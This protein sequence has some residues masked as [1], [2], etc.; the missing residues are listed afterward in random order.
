MK[1]YV[2]CLTN[3]LN[4]KR[5]VGKAND[6]QVRWES[7]VRRAKCGGQEHLCHAIR[8]WG[9]QAFKLEVLHECSSESEAF[10]IEH[11]LIVEW[12]TNDRHVGYNMNE[13]GIGGGKPNEEVLEKLRRPKSDEARQHMRGLKSPEHKQKLRESKMGERNHQYGRPLSDDHRA[14]ISD[15]VTGEKNGFFGKKHTDE[16]CERMRLAQSSE[17]VKRKVSEGVKASWARRKKAQE[18][19][20]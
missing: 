10:M 2:Y 6:P 4:G 7:H 18:A 14:K 3:T 9:S 17:E 5:Y 11:R 19:P 13:G 15:A 8:R 12:K 1:S 16:T 20:T